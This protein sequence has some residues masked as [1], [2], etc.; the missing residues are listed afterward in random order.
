MQRQDGPETV[1]LVGSESGSTWGPAATL[2]KA[3]QAAGQAVRVAA[4]AGFDPARHPRAERYPILAATYGEGDAPASAKVPER[5]HRSGTG[6][7]RP[8]VAILGLWRPQLPAFCAFAAEVEAAACG[9]VDAVADGRGRSPVA[10]GLRAGAGRL[11]RR[12]GCRLSLTI[13]PRAP[14][15]ESPT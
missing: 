7:Q 9:C 6:T 1:I 14:E 4:M 5:P 8:W 10:A 3:L 12:S 15:A 2:A 13:T 11:A